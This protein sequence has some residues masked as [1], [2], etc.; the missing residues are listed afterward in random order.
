VTDLE[1]HVA[2][3]TGGNGFGMAEGLARAGADV[4]IWGTNEDKNRAAAEALSRLGRSV[5][6]ERC[7]VSDE[8][9]VTSCFAR[10]LGALGKV[11]SVFA[12]AGIAGPSPHFVDLSLDEWR[13]VLGE[14]RRSLPHAARRRPASCRAGRRRIAGRGL[15][16]L[17]AA[18]RAA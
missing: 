6:V 18:R 3:V 7:D 10:T 12:N 15:V 16:N 4:A 13:N 11:D 9:Q 5:H 17:G 8:A 1:G 2:L 14:S